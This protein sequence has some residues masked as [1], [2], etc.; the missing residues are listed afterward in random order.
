MSSRKKRAT[1]NQPQLPIPTNAAAVLQCEDIAQLDDADVVA[2]NTALALDEEEAAVEQVFKE[3]KIGCLLEKLRDCLQMLKTIEE[4]PQAALN[5]TRDMWNHVGVT[6][7]I[8]IL[9]AS[10]CVQFSG[11]I[12]L[13]GVMT[14]AGI[15][16]GIWYKRATPPKRSVLLHDTFSRLGKGNVDAGKLRFVEFV[17]TQRPK[18]TQTA[19]Y[20]AEHVSTRQPEMTQT[21]AYT[22]LE[23][24]VFETP[25]DE[26]CAL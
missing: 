7:A 14:V 24:L 13:F 17:L 12:A 16:L 8:V 2:L 9:V 10:F 26:L 5:K 25:A 23:R 15:S 18:M 11:F 6:A 4:S 22:C 19:A 1:R 3:E 21:A 20:T